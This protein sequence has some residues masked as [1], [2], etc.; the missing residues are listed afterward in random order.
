MN[1]CNSA[2]T[3]Q[4]IVSTIVVFTMYD[5]FLRNVRMELEDSN[6]PYD[7][8][9]DEAERRFKE[10]HLLRLIDGVRFVRLESPFNIKHEGDVLTS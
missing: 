9:S 2:L 10:H 7:S 3:H 5:Q 6:I 1:I 4:F 8:L